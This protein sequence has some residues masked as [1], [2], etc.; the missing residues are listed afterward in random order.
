MKKSG[1]AL[2]E[3]A[4]VLIIMGLLANVGTKMASAMKKHYEITK[5]KNDTII[6]KKN[7]L[8]YIENTEMLPSK[9]YFEQ[10]FSSSLGSGKKLLYA[11]DNTF[12]NKSICSLKS[13]N[14]SIISKGY[15]QNRVIKNVLVAI[16]S[17]SANNNMQTKFI[18]NTIT[19]EKQGISI[20]DDTSNVNRIEPYDDQ[21]S[22]I[23][24][25]EA[26]N[27]AMC[28]LNKL[29]I[30]NTSLPSTT[31]DN[32][33]YY[34]ANIVIDGNFSTPS[35]SC[36][37]SDNKFSYSDGKVIHSNQKSKP[38]VVKVSCTVSADDFKSTKRF[39]ITVNDI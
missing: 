4:I 15:S 33:P 36:S 6:S 28:S 13:T 25:S 17:A 27:A 10:N 19:L 23:T 32:S 18:N 9:A 31:V 20:D 24:L 30:V 37:F 1:F 29:R 3:L 39:A 34:N 11:F 5:S 35:V 14:F 22:Y 21:A 2:V 7:I 12:L 16:V 8:G 38:G 26:Q